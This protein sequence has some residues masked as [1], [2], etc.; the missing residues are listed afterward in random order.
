LHATRPIAE[1][2]SN[3]SRFDG[4]RYGYRC[5]DPADLDDLYTRSRAEGFGD[6]VKRRIMVG[7]YAL[8]A[9]YF[10]AYY[11]KAQK[12]RRLIANDF[13]SA[14]Q[15]CDLILGPVS[16]TTAFKIGEKA[17]DPVA[18]YLTDIY[19]LS[20]NL[21]GVPGLSMPC[22]FVDGLPVGA[23]LLGPH[24]S[25]SSLLRT[26]F[27]YQQHTGSFQAP[28]P[29]SAP[30]PIGRRVRSISACRVCCRC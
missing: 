6:E 26:A 24:F 8:S 16:P 19:T 7:T 10:D 9:G 1:A 3:L 20:A 13:Q 21:A 23:Q 28:A 22:G 11:V 29:T 27:H 17:D 5:S 15:H 4:V 18:M 25:E 2:S 12:V 14:W 30:S